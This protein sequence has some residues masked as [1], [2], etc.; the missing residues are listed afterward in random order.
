MKTGEATPAG[1]VLGKS[2][3]QPS[4]ELAGKVWKLRK[5]FVLILSWKYPTCLFSFYFFIIRFKI[6]ARKFNL[7]TDSK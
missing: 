7:G 3:L 5:V 2:T 4:P 1:W 6:P